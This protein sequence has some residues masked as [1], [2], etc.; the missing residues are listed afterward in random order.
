MKNGNPFERRIRANELGRIA[1]SIFGKRNF[2]WYALGYAALLLLAAG[3]IPDGI[4]DLL[5]CQWSMLSLSALLSCCYK[6]IIA[7]LIILFFR[8]RLSKAIKE[9]S[10]IVVQPDKPQIVEVLGLF[11]SPLAAT[12]KEQEDELSAI[13][14]A[15]AD[16]SLDADF[17]NGKRWEVSLKAIDY[18]K[19]RLKQI[20]LF[21]SSGIRGTSAVSEDFRNVVEFLYPEI[22]VEEITPKGMNFEDIEKVFNAVEDFFLLNEKK[23]VKESDMLI[24]ITGG[25][26]TNSIAA[27]IATL[28]TGR[29]FQYISTESKDVRVFDVR[30]LEN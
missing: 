14:N 21:T 8:F 29:N 15:I 20:F 26:K 23:R 9:E 22:V 6:I 4:A 2:S 25:Q 30:Y 28:A 16:R 1:E 17:F 13:R 24:D 12:E 10:K 19:S 18:H 27:A 5:Q 11:L 3:W 7:F